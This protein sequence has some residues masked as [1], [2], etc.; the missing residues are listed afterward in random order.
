MKT[1]FD[2]AMRN[3]AKLTRRQHVIEATR[4]IQRALS[5]R[6]PAAPMEQPPARNLRLIEPKAAARPAESEQP[7]AGNASAGWRELPPTRGLS[8]PARP[9]GEVLTLLRR[10]NRPGLAP[11]AKPL[12]KAPVA[13]LPEGAAFLTKTFSCAAGS[14]DYKVYIPRHA[15]GRKRPLIV[16]LHGCTQDPDDFALGT[17]MNLLAEEQGFIAAYPRQPATANHSGC[18]NWFDLKDQMRGEGEPCIIAG[19]TRAIMAEFDI[20]AKRVYVAGLS[21][22]GAMALIMSATYPEL[23][24][25][26]GVHSGLAFGLATDL[27]S[28]FAAMRGDTSPEVMAQT[29]TRPRGARVRTIVFHG[30]SD[31]TV[32]PSNAGLIVADARAGFPGAAQETQHGRSA[33]GRA[34]T[35]TSIRDARGNVHVEHWAIDGLGHG[36]SGGRPEGSYTDPDG[37]D[38]SREMLRFFLSAPS[39]S[40]ARH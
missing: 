24:A 14:R 6:N 35:R 37:P 16:M 15:H 11:S 40:S 8:R 39:P 26:T 21:A 4:V 18:W 2:T 23:Y 28:A 33:G 17:G 1:I 31:R 38:A 19:I 27:P 12:K 3:A 34:Y 30:G 7:I 29:K 13:P 10:A 36:W 5:G 25:A 9:L 20:D 22:G 32:H